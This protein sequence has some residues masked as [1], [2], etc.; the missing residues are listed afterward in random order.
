MPRTRSAKPSAKSSNESST[1]ASS[2]TAKYEL[3]AE[4]KT[5][6]QIFI[7]PSKVTS[8]ARI[9]TLPHPRTTKPSRY[10]VC[11][12][13]GGFYEFTKIKAPKNSPRSWLVE[14]EHGKFEKKT[15]EDGESYVEVVSS[16]ELYLATT[17]DPVF[18]A[19]PSLFE[20]PTQKGSEEKKRRFLTSDDYFDKLP[21]EYSHLNEI[22]RWAKTRKL[23]E[24]RMAEICDTTDVGDEIMFRGSESKL[25]KALAKK[26]NQMS[27]GGLPKSMEDK[28]VTRPLEAP[29][30]IQKRQMVSG[31]VVKAAETAVSTPKTESSESQSTS[32]TSDTVLS[33]ASQ[34]STAA[35]SF[36]EPDEVE[37]GVTLAMTADATVVALQRLQVAFKFICEV[38][39][40]PD[41]A[42]QV[43]AD[44]A[45]DAKFAPLEEYL[46]KLAQAKSEVAAAR[47]IGDYS[48]KH[49][50]D[51][52][53]DEAREAKKRKDEEEKKRKAN[54][55]RGVRDLKKV[56][57]SGM[58][59][60]SHFFQKKQ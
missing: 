26:A 1:A 41:I 50:R 18:L 38:Y 17:F 12:D 36:T 60:L 4:H 5:L 25:L 39:I 19:I 55:S 13:T 24:D 47:S 33:A 23:L 45:K 28:F 20:L 46:S 29:M 3:P 31:E 49:G 7:L 21:E 54:E 32:T 57:T 58:K 22:L 37:D 43:E 42:K 27:E 51:E 9:V 16:A 40:Q 53:M 14:S 10:L 48:R 15:E 8:E 30:M 56:N 34:P 2:E 44:L 11:P 59:K 52:E 6:R 35:T